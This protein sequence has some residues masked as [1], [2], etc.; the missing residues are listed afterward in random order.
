MHDATEADFDDAI[1]P[2][3]CSSK[4]DLLL[5]FAQFKDIIACFTTAV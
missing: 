4:L 2:V 5:N 3:G 1:E